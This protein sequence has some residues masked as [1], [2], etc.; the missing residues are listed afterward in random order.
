MA[1]RKYDQKGYQQTAD[2]PPCICGYV[3]PKMLPVTWVVSPRSKPFETFVRCPQCQKGGL[4]LKLAVLSVHA[5]PL[6]LD[7]GE[8][9]N[10]G[11][12]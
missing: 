7:S 3:W 1:T 2:L 9:V 4:I 10:E 12:G 5:Y 11:G 6:I 8:G